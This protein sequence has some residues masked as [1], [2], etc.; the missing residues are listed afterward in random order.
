MGAARWTE[1]RRHVSGMGAG[2]R[3]DRRVLHRA[4]GRPDHR[5]AA[6]PHAG[7]DTGVPVGC[8]AII[9]VI[10]VALHRRP[11]RLRARP[12][13]PRRSGSS[14][15]R[16]S[17][18]TRTIV[19]IPIA[20][21]INI[22]LGQ[23]VA[24]ALKVPDLPRLDRDDPRRRPRRPDRR[25]DH[26]RPREP[27][28]DLRPACARSTPTTPRR[29]SSSPSR[30]GSSPASPA[31]SGSSGAARTR[32]GTGSR[33]GRSSS[34][35]IVAVIGIYGFIPFYIEQRRHVFALPR[36]ARRRRPIF[37]VPGLRRS[38]SCSSPRCWA[39]SPTSSSGATWAPPTS[40]SPGSVC[41]IISAIISAPISAVVFGG[42]TGSGTDLLVA[43]FQQAGDDL[44]D[45]RPQAGPARPTRSTRRSR[46]SSSSPSSAR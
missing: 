25:R 40:S 41:G 35:L 21:A 16:A 36:R 32:R 30:S 31:G 34:S 46:S 27:D 17:S 12:S 15:S 2:D 24:A 29:S 42:V 18:S 3:R 23:T 22:I 14:R 45:R 39:C 28:L 13:T 7:S 43:A 4:A 26:R 1:D 19:L 11:H 44:V 9:A 20:I 10:G 33:S 6:R 37:V 5:R 8:N 38:R